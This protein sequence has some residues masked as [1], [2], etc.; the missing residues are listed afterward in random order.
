VAVPSSLFAFLRRFVIACVLVVTIALGGLAVGDSYERKTFNS[1]K[2]VHIPGGI[3]HKVEP[4]KPANYVL[5][6]VDTRSTTDS[7]SNA[8]T[9]MV[10]HV[11]PATGTGYLVSFPRD[12]IVDV[13]GHGRSLLNAAYADGGANG[14]ALVIQTLE[15]N[16][17]PL[18]IQH[19]IEVDFNGFQQIVNAIGK[20]NL[21]FPT[22]VHDPYIGLDIEQRGCIAVDGLNALR[23]ARSRHY[24]VPKDLQSPAPWHWNYPSQSGGRGWTTT[25]SDIDRIP[26]QQYF[27]RTIAAAALSKTASNPTKLIALMNA[28]SSNFTHDDTLTLGELKT[29]IRTFKGFDPRRVQMTT[30]PWTPGTGQYTN[31]VLAKQPQAAFVISNL[32]NKPA[33]VFIPKLLPHST[34][35]VRVVNGSG[36]SGLAANVLAQFE[37]AGYKAAGPAADADRSNYAKTI[38]QYRPG[39]AE[40]GLTVLESAGAKA[41]LEQAQSA[42]ATLGGDVLVVIGRDWD[43]ITHNLKPQTTTTTAA[44]AATGTASTGSSTTVAAPSTTTTTAP[45]V[46]TRY[47]PVDPKTGGELVGCPSS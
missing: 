45:T 4:G 36:M 12:L 7:G 20:I 3:I 47:V 38:V 2:T 22:P 11:E 5:I 16:F 46:D 17:P 26:R 23:Y 39:K 40:E 25:G 24:Y 42:A 43:H 32:T 30:L 19:Y 29:L 35:K 21:W 10:L 31:R 13:P 9:I 41:T 37:A 18:S 14:G 27:L 6:G 8:D 28:V 33:P 34:I 15:Q 44:T 1:T